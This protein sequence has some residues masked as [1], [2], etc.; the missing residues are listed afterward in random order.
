MKEKE[1]I[2]SS[3]GFL[4][5]FFKSA[6][7]PVPSRRRIFSRISRRNN[8]DFFSLYPRSA[9][10]WNDVNLNPSVGARCV[11]SFFLI[12]RLLHVQRLPK[13]APIGFGRDPCL[14]VSPLW[15]KSNSHHRRTVFIVETYSTKPAHSPTLDYKWFFFFLPHFL[16]NY[17]NLLP[18]ITMQFNIWNRCNGM[19]TK[20]IP[21]VSVYI[22]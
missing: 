17:K 19:R 6:V 4:Y 9:L 15:F 8:V 5:T 12:L 1:K 2:I 21:D 22:Y 13:E 18:R 20:S 14:I 3:D 16:C 10:W 7:N 11:F